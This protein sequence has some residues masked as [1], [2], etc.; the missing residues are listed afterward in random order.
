VDPFYQFPS[1]LVFAESNGLLNPARGFLLSIAYEICQYMM[2]TEVPFLSSA[3]CYLSEFAILGNPAYPQFN[4]YDIR[5]GEC[6]TA[7]SCYDYN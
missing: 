5:K 4:L 2:L 3:L 6:T 1:H 7:F